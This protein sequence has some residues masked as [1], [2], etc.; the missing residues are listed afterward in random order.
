M[1]PSWNP[2]WKYAQSGTENANALASASRTDGKYTFNIDYDSLMQN[3]NDDNIVSL[4]VSSTDFA[5]KSK[6]QVYLS[7][8]NAP[9]MTYSYRVKPQAEN[10][11]I[12]GPDK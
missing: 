5:S 11:K 6:T 12:S 8:D 9:K 10:I 7:G 1:L 4:F 3:V 2:D